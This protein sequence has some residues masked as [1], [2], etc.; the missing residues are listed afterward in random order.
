[1]LKWLTVAVSVWFLLA[2]ESARRTGIAIHQPF[3]QIDPPRAI[4]STDRSDVA[5]RVCLVDLDGHLV[6]L[7]VQAVAVSNRAASST[8]ARFE[9]DPQLHAGVEQAAVP[10]VS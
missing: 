9:A 8:R 1:M 4:F 6:S 7:L 5:L 3:R 10:P 2:P